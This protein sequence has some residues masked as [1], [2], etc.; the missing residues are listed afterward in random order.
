MT[1]TAASLLL[2]LALLVPAGSLGS[3]PAARAEGG[4]AGKAP[5]G[6]VFPEVTDA[7]AEEAKGA[8]E[9][10]KKALEAKD[11]E[12][13]VAALAPM[14]KKKHADFVPE[15]KKLLADKRDAVAGAAAEALGSQADKGA[16]T[17]LVKVV[18]ADTREKGI[19][20][21]PILKS[22]AIEALG[23]LG[24]GGAFDPVHKLSDAMIQNPEVTYRYAPRVSKACVRYYG[25]TKEKRAVSYLIDEVER[26]NLKGGVLPSSPPKEYWKYR[27][28][29]WTEIRYEV[30]WAL[31]EIT[32]KEFESTARWESWFNTEGKK[33]GMK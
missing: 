19:L 3:P 13:V 7:S 27:Q 8:V 6:G 12:K 11:D 33:A 22:A 4:D 17:L 5:K 25:L 30:V 20:R 23:R 29:I 16:A 1:R 15:L 10:L 28:D 2:A 21:D 14:V 31:K 24:G 26:P 9:A 18:T 32:G